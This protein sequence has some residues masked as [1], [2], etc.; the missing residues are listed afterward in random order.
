MPSILSELRKELRD[1]RK[2]MIKPVS[3]MLKHE[4]IM[5]LEKHRSSKP[6]QEESKAEEKVE[7]VVEKVAPKKVVKKA[8]EKVAEVVEKK[9]RRK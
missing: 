5:E 9:S 6:K 4:V 2:G 7:K 8:V 1:A 3:R